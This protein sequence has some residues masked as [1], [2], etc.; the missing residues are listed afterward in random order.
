MG[1]CRAEKGYTLIE[2]LVAMTILAMAMTVLFRVFSGGLRN[3]GIAGDYARAVAIAESQLAAA[4]GTRL[5][6]GV[7]QGAIADRYEWTR[8]VRQLEVAD[9]R[10]SG[11][12]AYEVNVTVAWE[13]N[14]RARQVTLSSVLL[15]SGGPG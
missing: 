15:E 6:P 12:S 10:T 1:S 2:V 5:A 4:D 13:Q 7:E 14:G 8:A 9:T 11:V 3:V